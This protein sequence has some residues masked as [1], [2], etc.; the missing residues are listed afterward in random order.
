MAF[1]GSP[2]LLKAGIVLVDAATG[3]TQRV[4]NLQYNP[5]TLTRTLQVQGVGADAGDRSETLRL[6]GPPIEVLKLDAEIDAID[7]LE[8]ADAHPNAV[9]LGIAPALAALEVL[10]YPPSAQ[11]RANRD[12]ARIG[13]LEIVPVL[14]P[15]TVFVWGKNRV[16]P[17]RITEFS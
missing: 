8:H 16:M 9:S 11:H 7:Q 4:I 2:L 12:L 17:V 13:T 15:L 5:D 6:K 1:P 10:V 14:S 3:A